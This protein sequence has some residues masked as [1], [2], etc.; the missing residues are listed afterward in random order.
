MPRA[1]K[2]PRRY[3]AS[4]RQEQ[5]RVT[6]RAVL[7]AARDR[8]LDEGYA[9]TTVAAVAAQ[10]GVS[11]ETVYKAFGN[12]PGLVKAVLDVSIVGDDEPVPMMQ[13]EFVQ[14]NIAE[15]D[16]RRK[17]L[18]FGVHLAEVH[19]RVSPLELVVRAAAAADP[20][21]AEVWVTLQ[22]ER[23][24][25]MTAFGQHLQDHG[26]L[27][28]GVSAHEARDVLWAHSSVELWDL[29]VR[30]RGWP[31]E[32]YAAWLGH[33]LVAAL[34]PAGPTRRPARAPGRRGG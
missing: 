6:R 32:R 1:V 16:P 28:D 7:D 21:V 23:L 24:T 27:R 15:P 11:V 14:R 2:P 12:K 34:L 5:A 10:A 17:L 9:R 29:L 25:G 19:P 26:H 8:F 33:Q 18:D 4:R 30:Q 22:D 31:D 3:D 13:R 20:A